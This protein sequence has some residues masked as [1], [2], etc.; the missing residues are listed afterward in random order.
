MHQVSEAGLLL[1]PAVPPVTTSPA[2]SKDTDPPVT[3]VSSPLPSLQ[4]KGPPSP[5][6]PAAT[7]TEG[8]PP[9]IS[10]GPTQTT[11]GSALPASVA[12][13]GVSGGGDEE[14]MEETGAHNC[15]YAPMCV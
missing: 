10:L 7:G 14:A 9:V 6:R 12:E 2:G 8:K 1:T 4:L 13:V 15:V 11:T 5:V 3:F